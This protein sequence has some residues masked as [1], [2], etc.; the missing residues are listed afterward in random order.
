MRSLWLAGIMFGILI[1]SISVSFAADSPSGFEVDSVFLKTAIK[2]GSSLDNQI[3]I[4]NIYRPSGLKNF[5]F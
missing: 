1:L 3:K 2:T 5:L 4:T